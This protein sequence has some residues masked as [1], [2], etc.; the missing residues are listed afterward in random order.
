MR[1]GR[2]ERQRRRLAQHDPDVQFLRH[3]IFREGAVLAQHRLAFG[4]GED[5][6]PGG[7]HRPDIVQLELEQRDHAEVAAATAQG[8]EQVGLLGGAGPAALAI[9][10]HHLAAEQVIHSHAVLARQPAKPAAERQPGHAGGGVDAERRGQPER[11]R[12]VV[13]IGQQ[14][15]AADPGHFFLGIDLDTAVRGEVD[16]QPVRADRTACDIV[17]AA[18][19]GQH[20]PAV[21]REVD[22]LDHVGGARTLHDDGGPLV[23]SGVPDG[24]GRVI[25]RVGGQ[26]DLAAHGLAQHVEM[27]RGQGWHGGFLHGVRDAGDETSS[28]CKA[29][30]TIAEGASTLACRPPPPRAACAGGRKSTDRLQR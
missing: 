28:P 14:G 29:R 2:Q 19:H 18:A 17:S 24:A 27:G 6:Q 22:G 12:L 1:G 16:D 11:L 7:D 15:A 4:G 9:G 5:K 20:Q 8:P 23:H 21:S 26:Q 10:G 25:A 30:A 3:R 13:E